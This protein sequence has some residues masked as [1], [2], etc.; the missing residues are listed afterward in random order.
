[1]FFRLFWSTR[2]AVFLPISQNCSPVQCLVRLGA[3]FF[4]ISRCVND[5]YR[6]HP[7]DGKV[8]VSVC[9]VSL[10]VQSVHTPP[11]GGVPHLHAIILPLVPC[12]F[13]GYPSDWSQVPSWGLPHS[14]S[15]LGQDRWYPKM[16][17]TP[18]QGWGTPQPGRDGGGGTWDGV[19]P[20]RNGIPN[21]PGQ[22]E[23][24][25]YPPAR[26]GVPLGDRT[27]YGVLDTWRAVCLLRSRRRICFTSFQYVSNVS[28]VS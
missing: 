11:G 16:G 20:S 25:G 21:W 4:F 5:F 3:I 19:P 8:I 9:S 10:F 1:M 24:R 26:D 14:C 13:G 18:I 27:A 17:Y 7:K 15:W 22:D 2:T 28:Q 6:P 12:P 23:G